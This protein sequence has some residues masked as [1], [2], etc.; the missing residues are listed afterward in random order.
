MKTAC[1]PFGNTQSE[2]V[3]ILQRKLSEEEFAGLIPAHC[4]GDLDAL[5]TSLV[6][7]LRWGLRESKASPTKPPSQIAEEC[8]LLTDKLARSRR[9]QARSSTIPEEIRGAVLSLAIER[10]I[11]KAAQGLN[12]SGDH[13]WAVFAASLVT[14]FVFFLIARTRDDSEASGELENYEGYERC[15]VITAQ[16][17][18]ENPGPPDPRCVPSPRIIMPDELIE[19]LPRVQLEMGDFMCRSPRLKENPCFFVTRAGKC[20]FGAPHSQHPLS[21]VLEGLVKKKVLE[22]TVEGGYCYVGACR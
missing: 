9:R 10:A 5:A 20:L 1:I 21:E 14:Y 19:G 15:V 3:E 16:R 18:S 6:N 8:R 7:A 17:L 13:D 2:F 11:E 22:E 4:D 12:L